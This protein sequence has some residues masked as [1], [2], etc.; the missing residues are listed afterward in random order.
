L[1]Q[2]RP[3]PSRRTGTAPIYETGPMQSGMLVG[4]DN[5]VSASES[6]GLVQGHAQNLS[7][8]ALLRLCAGGDTAALEEL[9]RRY[10]TPLHRFL[11]RLMGSPDD[12]EEAALDVFVRVWQHA[13]RFQ[14]RA[15]VATWLYRI[16]VNIAHDAHSRR[17]AR[18]QEALP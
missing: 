3:L 10:Q 2:A 1:A 8:E 9:V 15:K 4:V 7:D 13:P 5:R 16:A 18:P 17:K 12:A 14:Y 6:G 11:A